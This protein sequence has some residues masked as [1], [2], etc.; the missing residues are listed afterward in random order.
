MIHPKN[1][2][3]ILLFFLIV[4]PLYSQ[5]LKGQIV[6][7]TTSEGLENVT[8]LA[9][10]EVVAVSDEKGNFLIENVQF[11]IRLQFRALGFVTLTRFFEKSPLDLIISLLPSTENL[12]EVTIRS[13]LIDTK[14]QHTPAAIG[15]LSPEDLA[16]TEAVN[17]IDNLNYVPGVYI[18]Q[19]ALNTNK[20]NIRGIGA[21]AQYSTN[22]VQAYFDGI[23]LTTAEG[24]LTLDD[25]DQESIERIE[26][27]KGP[28]SSRYGAGLGG[29][30]NLYSSNPAHHRSRVG[31]KVQAGSYDTWKK[32]DVVSINGKK[33]AVF[34]TYN[35]AQSD[36]WRENGSYDR[37]SGLINTKLITS[38]KNSLSF[39]ANF[40]K[41]KAYI[42][43]SINEDDFLN[44]PEKA[45]YTW[46]TAKGYESYDRGLLGVSYQH[47]FNTNLFN[48]T[49]VFLSFRNGY[50]PRPFDILK[51][52]RLSAGVR[53]NFNLKL[54]VFDLPSIL[55]FGA[56]YYQEWYETGTFE[57]LYEDFENR[58]S[59]RGERLSN[60]EQNRHYANFFAQLN[61]DVTKRLAVEAGFNFNTTGYRLDDFYT[62]DEIDQ[63]GS[64]TFDA[65]FSPRIG[66]SYEVGESKN[67]YASVS[68]GFSTPTVAE[69]L[70]PEGRIN[71]DL[72]AEQ[73]INY[74]IGFKGNWLNNTLYTEISAYS[75]Q[76][77]NLL[78][79]QRV[80][81]DQYVGINAGKTDH[82][83]I[84]IFNKYT[85]ML[86]KNWKITPFLNTAINFFE[87]DK[88]INEDTDYSGNEL[89]GV[90]KH[91]LNVG[92]DVVSDS[93]F[94]FNALYRNVGKIPLND[95]NILYT[96]SYNLVNLK[97]AYAFDII[98]DLQFKVYGGINNVF[99]EEYAASVLPNAVGFGGAAPRYYY[100]GYPR[101][102]YSGMT[103]NYFF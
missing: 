85:I 3:F 9:A 69:T 81:E 93:G 70:T 38:E 43:S 64:Y 56:Q 5:H 88:F 29:A 13:T 96:D 25:I 32:S 68:H 54:D 4:P 102:Y 15:V 6:N 24:A 26:I 37:K 94:S 89:P 39:L 82:N 86:A 34:A 12:S 42:P 58:G 98:P 59:V 103:I 7:S 62:E 44:N 63:T 53:T 50:E 47:H 79:A 23:P 73:G 36:G 72:K 31:V 87:F 75:I 76:V 83:G 48:Q 95:A 28:T 41:L 99:E 45:A 65:V 17:F 84:E 66:L 19:G 77:K 78:V 61:I 27:I 14:L 30:I 55:S 92:F 16:R 67:L 21:R 97:A 101:N 40:V 11:P 71:T 33:T 22:R 100:P 18:N 20:I 35:H 10:S 2:I 90:P 57:N 51:E 49:S 1:I 46:G 74:E 60:N 91:T 80:A 52:E 8:V